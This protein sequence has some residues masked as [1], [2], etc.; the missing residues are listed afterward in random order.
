MGAHTLAI[1]ASEANIAIASLH[2]ASADPRLLSP[3]ASGIGSLTYRHAPAEALVQEP[4][5][6]DVV[7]SM[8]VIEHVDNPADF[9]K[10][11]AEL[12]KVC[13]FNKY[14]K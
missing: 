12:V 10:S 8:E 4:R 3:N 2:T 13:S 9:L 11:L 1:D 6:F 7:C 14:S 5:R